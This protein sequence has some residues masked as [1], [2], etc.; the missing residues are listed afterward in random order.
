MRIGKWRFLCGVAGLAGLA[1]YLAIVAIASAQTKDSKQSLSSQSPQGQISGHVYRG[2]TSEPVSK[3]QVELWGTT[4][5]TVHAAGGERIVRTAVDGAFVFSDLPAGTYQIAVS[6]NGYAGFTWVQS[7]RNDEGNSQEKL[8]SL[9]PGEK[10]D[11]LVL[12][13][14]PAGIIAGQITDEDHDPV[15]KLEVMALTVDYV[16]GGRKR[17]NLAGKTATDDLGNFRIA[18]LPPGPYYVKAGGLMVGEMRAVALK[19]GPAGGVQYRDTYHPGAASLG[20]AQALQV[21]G[22][23]TREADFTVPSQRTYTISGKVLQGAERAEQIEWKSRETEGYTFSMSGDTADVGADGSFKIPQLPPGEYTLTASAV[24]SGRENDLGYASVRIVDSDVRADIEIGRA[25][26]VSGKVET[27]RGLSLVGKEI[28]LQTFGPG[29]YLLHSAAIDSGGHFDIRNIPPGE[30]TFSI[31]NA[32]AYVK[33]AI[34]NGQDDASSV[35]TL[36]LDTTLDCAVTV[37]NDTSVVHGKIADG[38]AP[39]TKAVAVLIP[40]SRELRRN[41]RYTLTSKT[42]DSGA[43]SISGVI[44]GDY[45]LFAVPPSKDHVYFALDFA[46]QQGGEQISVKPSATQAVDLK[47]A[48]SE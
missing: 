11:G 34:C 30:F 5:E 40:E 48:K 28:T 4:E 42:D 31:S 2:N 18:N 14:Q 8:I 20:E 38:E 9:Q 22:D 32:D 37:A 36:M 29:F 26:G 16:H 17:I 45:L 47:L 24:Q 46:D 33:K 43:Y 13:L 27:P 12:R 39:A 41:P 44:P 10:I 21:S 23:G 19:Q 6:H 15:Q 1:A 35:F 3:A 7:E 25:A